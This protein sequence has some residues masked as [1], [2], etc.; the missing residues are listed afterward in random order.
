MDLLNLYVTL[1]YDFILIEKLHIKPMFG[2]GCY[3]YNRRLYIDETWSK[4]F[5]TLNYTFEYEFR[6]IAPEKS[7]NTLFYIGGL[8]INYEISEGF[9]LLGAVK[10]TNI[11]DSKLSFGFDK[12]PFKNA[13][14]T[15]LGLTILY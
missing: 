4:Y 3:F 14:N 5:S 2:G 7:G 11:F 8:E 1:D 6:N 10:Y 9:W 13:V 12:M 15:N